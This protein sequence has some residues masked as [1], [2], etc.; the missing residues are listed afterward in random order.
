MRKM[1]LIV[2]SLAV[3]ALLFGMAGQAGAV[4]L[5]ANSTGKYEGRVD[6]QTNASGRLEDFQGTIIDKAVGPTLTSVLVATYATSDL[7]FTGGFRWSERITNASGLAWTG[8]SVTINSNST[9]TFLVQQGAPFRAT[10][11]GLPDLMPA[12]APDPLVTQING[13]VVTVSA[14]GKTVTFTAGG[15]AVLAAGSR[16]DIHIPIHNL[17]TSTS[18]TLTETATA[19]PVTPVPE[20]GS[21]LLLGSALA[22]LGL[23]ARKRI[24]H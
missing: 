9:G 6:Y 16:L 12:A 3:L 23:W 4:L 2:L 10:I 20:P 11:N 17:G 5:V 13:T 15:G 18:F 24:S 1:R 22:G 7:D 14:D 21:L 19:A 8:F